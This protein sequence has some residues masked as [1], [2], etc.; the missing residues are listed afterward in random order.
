L[1]MAVGAERSDV[2]S[3]VMKSGVH[4]VLLGLL[5]GSVGVFFAVR[6]LKAMLF[7]VS[8]FDLT[9]TAAAMLLIVVTALGAALAP[10]IRAASI[11]PM[12]ALRTE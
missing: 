6:V 10:A 2:L 7:G 8:S 4:V 5:I 9:S 12:S 3:L 11:E 1:R